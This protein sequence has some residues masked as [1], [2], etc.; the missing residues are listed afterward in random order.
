MKFDDPNDVS[1][2]QGLEEEVEDSE[3]SSQ[4]DGDNTCDIC[5]KQFSY[6]R[7]LLQHKEI[8]HNIS[9]GTKR[10]KI[11]L[12][13]CE[14]KCLICD[15]TMKVGESNAHNRTHIANN[16]KPRNWYT[17]AECGDTFKACQSLADHIK[18]VHR[19][20]RSVTKKF[21]VTNMADFCEVV[22]TK[23]EPLDGIQIHNDI[24][25]VPGQ[26][27]DGKKATVDVVSSVKW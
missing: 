24:E 18:M 27:V 19:L 1:Q 8:K 5:E 10:A 7:L 4:D 16:M 9:S 21:A 13:N 11:I 20:K 25:G 2:N 26:T 12:K 23:T 22:V 3:G 6:R 17:C 15:I 14:V